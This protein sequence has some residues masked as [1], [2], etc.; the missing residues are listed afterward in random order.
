MKN[1]KKFFTPL[2]CATLFLSLSTY[3]HANETENW[4]YYSKNMSYKWAAD[5]L[6]SVVKNGW[7]NAVNSWNGKGVNIYYY[8]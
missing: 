2:L 7:S 1:F 3:V 5:S 4:R 6:T 8:K